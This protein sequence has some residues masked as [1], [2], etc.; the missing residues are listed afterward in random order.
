MMVQLSKYPTILLL[1]ILYLNSTAYAFDFKQDFQTTYETVD[2]SDRVEL[3]SPV[4]DPK[5]ALLDDLIINRQRDRNPRT[6][7]ILSLAVPGAGQSYN[8]DYLKTGVIYGIFGSLFY[9]MD[10]NRNQFDRFNIAYEQRL[11]GEPD[12]FVGLIPNARGIRNFRDRYR[13]DLELTYIGIGAAYLF[14]VIDAF[15]SAHL[16]TFDV[17]DDLSFRI[18]PT[19][20]T[21]FPGSAV[22]AGIVFTF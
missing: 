21:M 10:F 20:R 8:G 6:A 2:T 9:A 18:E 22:G 11:K 7:V 17:S 14:N 15:V 19:I 12:E 13:K 5:M 16:T 1:G 4:S 3:Q